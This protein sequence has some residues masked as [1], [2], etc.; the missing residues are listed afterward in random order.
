[1]NN[2]MLLG[3]YLYTCSALEKHPLLFIQNKKDQFLKLSL[4]FQKGITD[5]NSLIDALTQVTMFFQDGHTNIELPY[6]TEDLCLK[7]LCEWK[8]D[9]LVLTETFMD[10]PAGAKIVSVED[11]SVSE[12][13]SFAE[14]RIPH[15]NR[16]L[17]KAER[18]SIRIK[19]IIYSVQ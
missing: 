17:V 15:E 4:K 8:K 11:K 16:Y 1:M 12:L 9:V 19:I 13:L 7:I 3:D 2:S 14:T 6:T 18:L 5:Y 10:I